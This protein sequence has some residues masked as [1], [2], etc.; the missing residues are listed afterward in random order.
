MVASPE[1]E[2]RAGRPADLEAIGHIQAHSAGASQWKPAEY[3]E[4]DLRVA[5][6]G[7]VLA[8]FVVARRVAEGESEILNLAVAPGFRRR[9]VARALVAAVLAAHPGEVFLEVR[10]SNQGGRA[11]YESIGFKELF[12]RPGYY[13]DPPEGAVVMKFCS[14]YCQGR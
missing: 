5:V 9:G 7:G 6:A 2:V 1:I 3:L 11:F 4:H 8:G 12:Y 10:E 14:C 13:S